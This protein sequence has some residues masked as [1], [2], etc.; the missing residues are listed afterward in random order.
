MRGTVVLLVLLFCL[1]GAWTQ[2]ESG[3]VRESDITQPGHSAGSESRGRE[4]QMESQMTDASEKT[5]KQTTTSPDIWTEMKELRN[6]VHNLGTTVVEQSEKL[7]NMEVR[8]TASE[9]EAKEQRNTVT[10]L[11]VELMLTKNKVEEVEKENADLTAGLS[12]SK[13][14]VE[15]LQTK[16]AALETKLSASESQVEELKRATADRPKVA[17]SAGLTDSGTVGPFVAETTLVYTKIFSNIGKA[18][19]PATGVFTAPVRGLYYI[20][21]TAMSVQT[22]FY[23]YAYMYKNG[24]KIMYSQGYNA[25]GYETLS[26]GVCLEL[27]EGDVVYMRIPASNRLYDNSNNHNIFSGFLLFTV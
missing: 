15:E 2:E 9:A 5:N 4:V 10:D 12:G 6:M 23:F 24:Q 7:R 19:N 20:S 11:R 14:R 1:S 26:N 21:F 17:F 27:E 8:A 3:G 16:N 13:S 18:Y 22:S 25:G